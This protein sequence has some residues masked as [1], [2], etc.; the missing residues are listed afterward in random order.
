[1]ESPLTLAA[2]KESS[3]YKEKRH[4]RPGKGKSQKRARKEAQED[5]EERQLSS[6][7]F[8]NTTTEIHE[9]TFDDKEVN[10]EEGE[11]EFSFQIDRTGNSIEEIE[12]GDKNEEEDTDNEKYES[13]NED[14]S[15]EQDKDAPA[16]VDPDDVAVSLV[17]SSSRLKKLRD[18]RNE[19]K[20]LTG[21]EL[22]HRLRKRYEQSTQAT[23]RTDWARASA[24]TN[25]EDEAATMLF[26]TSS[27]LLATS[28]NRLPPN[29]LSI[30]RCPDANL[31]DPNKAVVQAVHFH[32]GSDPDE[33]LLLTAG[34]DK[35][36]RFFQVGREK[37]EKIHGIHCKCEVFLPCQTEKKF[38]H[39]LPCFISSQTANLQ[40]LVFGKH[41]KCR[42]KWPTLL[43]LHIRC[44]S[45]ESRL[46][47]THTRERRK[48]VGAAYSIARWTAYSL[49]RK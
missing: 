37:S 17:D 19:T 31:A 1:M 41:W 29:N 26:S 18:S 45:R 36:L 22:E 10:E 6:L 16:W 20:A 38:T 48:V 23:A 7:I 21:V 3:S 14:E 4:H 9:K 30:V 15:N 39:S 12:V 44:C 5:S 28:R 8:G 24:K 43:L 33:P 32:P 49:C 27:S 47:A 13:S 2:T 46:G 35:T 25:D 11:E 34:L 42:S 40:R